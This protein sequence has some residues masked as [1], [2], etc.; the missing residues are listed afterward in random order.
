MNSRLAAALA[1]Q[2]D[3]GDVRLGVPRQHRQQ[4][5]FADAGAGEHAQALPPAARQESVDRAHA[6]VE[7]SLNTLA[8]VGR[9][10][11]LRSG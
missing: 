9:R 6:E 3:H 11:A 10:R 1:D 5:G 8:S 7:L 4:A 2:A